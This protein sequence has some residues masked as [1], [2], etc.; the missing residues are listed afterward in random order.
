[1]PETELG[2]LTVVFTCMPHL[3]TISGAYV[4]RGSD[5]LTS[6][7]SP[8]QYA[9]QENN[10]LTKN[11]L[12]MME[13]NISILVEPLNR[14]IGVRGTS[15]EQVRNEGRYSA[16]QSPIR[17]RYKSSHRSRLPH[18]RHHDHRQRSVF[19]ISLAASQYDIAVGSKSDFVYHNL[20]AVRESQSICS[21][22]GEA[23]SNVK[24]QGLDE[25]TL[26]IFSEINS[27]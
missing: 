27:S 25:K 1:M 13:R 23:G 26:D 21:Q 20:P 12:Q 18:R 8:A 17:H 24:D 14:F 6:S 22:V 9:P 5:C 7:V 4:N 16:R 10:N 15:K 2:N 19:P 11:R 3:T